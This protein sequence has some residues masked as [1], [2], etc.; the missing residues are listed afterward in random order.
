MFGKKVLMVITGLLFSVS[1]SAAMVTKDWSNL[2]GGS[3]S[4]TS[5][6]NSVVG[7][8]TVSITAW[9]RN[10]GTVDPAY[11]YIDRRPNSNHDGLGVYTGKGDSDQIDG[12]N[13]TA[14]GLRL[15]FS[16]KVT[17]YM[18]RLLDGDHDYSFKKGN[19]FDL[20][21]DGAQVQNDAGIEALDNQGRIALPGYTGKTFL[22][23]ADYKDDNFYLNGITVDVPE[24]GTLGLLVIG[25]LGLSFARRGR[26]A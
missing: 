22:L 3:D 25:L 13:R 15:T 19:D 2:G 23:T 12:A 1:A 10:N 5:V 21:V 18:I 6:F 7:P 20:W 16:Q 11:V 8:A 4:I 9:Q 24:P 17:L 26:K 14:E